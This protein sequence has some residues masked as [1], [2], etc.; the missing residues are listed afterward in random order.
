MPEWSNIDWEVLLAHP[1]NDAGPWL[2]LG[3]AF[4]VV[5]VGF[6]EMRFSKS[7]KI[8]LSTWGFAAPPFLAAL[9]WVATWE[10]L[11]LALRVLLIAGLLIAAWKG[12]HFLWRY[13]ERFETKS[14]E[15]TL[16]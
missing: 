11:I 4:A 2:A 1:G 15:S 13:A 8:G 6:I 5:F 7:R 14:Q 3:L 9:F 16:P 12:L 10:E